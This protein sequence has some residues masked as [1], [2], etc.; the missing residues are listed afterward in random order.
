MTKRRPG[1]I[2]WLRVA[3][4]VGA[5][6][7]LW[8]TAV[9]QTGRLARRGWWRRPPFLPLPGADYLRFRMETQYG[10]ELCPIRSSARLAFSLR[11]WPPASWPSES[12][13]LRLFRNA[14]FFADNS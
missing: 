13:W 1:P 11:R 6:P 5:R 14:R 4:A 10:D 8:P 9:R 2:V 12:P 7:G 3:V